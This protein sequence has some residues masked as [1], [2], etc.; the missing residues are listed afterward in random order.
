MYMYVC[1]HETFAASCDVHGA[2]VIVATLLFHNYNYG[3]YCFSSFFYCCIIQA[4]TTYCVCITILN[5][6]RLCF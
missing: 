3:D 5:N 6:F 4:Q 2:L 1:N